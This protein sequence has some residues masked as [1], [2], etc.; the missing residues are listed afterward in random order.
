MAMRAANRLKGEVVACYKAFS[1]VLIFLPICLFSGQNL[2]IWQQFEIL[3]W[4]LISLISFG[5]IFSIHLRSKALK[6]YTVSGLQQ[7]NFVQLL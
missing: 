1:L 4:L 3:D 7:F 5:T 2:Q 6:N